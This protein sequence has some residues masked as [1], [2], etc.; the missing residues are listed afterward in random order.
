MQPLTF[1]SSFYDKRSIRAKLAFQF[2]VIFAIILSVVFVAV[3]ELS[4]ISR[5][6]A[7]RNQLKDRAVTAAEVFLAS[8]NTTKERFAEIRR[9]YLDKLPAEII[10]AYD[11]EN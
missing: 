2:T 1:L 5:R 11:T 6:V 7:F 8:D 4:S 10:R 9:E 3:Y